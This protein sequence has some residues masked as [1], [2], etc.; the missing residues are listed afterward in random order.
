MDTPRAAWEAGA[1]RELDWWRRYLAGRGLGDAAGFRSRFDPQA[2]LPDHVAR[3]LPEGRPAS[4]IRIL[5]CAAGPATTLGSRLGGERVDLVAADAL[6][7]AYAAMLDDLGLTP[8][9]PSRRAEVERLDASF[10]PGTFDLVYMRF[11]LD[12]CYDP[13]QALRQMARVLRPGGTLLIEHYRDEGEVTYEGL[14]RW[15][16]LP[17]PPAEL[18]IA[19]E[20]SRARLSEILPGSRIQVEAT[21]TW[22]T[23][24]VRPSSA[25]R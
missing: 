16:L 19:N 25:P 13:P 12:H 3:L 23:A 9:V 10:E 24:T 11:A 17:Q 2:Q 14:R 15:T 8:P 20:R 5:D 4:A 18:V 22:L 21:P 1:A 6:A 7:D